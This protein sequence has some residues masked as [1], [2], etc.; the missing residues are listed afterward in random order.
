MLAEEKAHSRG[1]HHVHRTAA[2]R[3]VMQEEQEA[4][5]QEKRMVATEPG[6]HIALFF[7]RH[8]EITALALT[9]LGSAAPEWKILEK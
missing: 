4:K 8:P 2:Q 5:L 1:R 6:T 7:L 9:V 3:T